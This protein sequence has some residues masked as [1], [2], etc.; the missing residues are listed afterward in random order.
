MQSSPS[1]VICHPLTTNE[2]HDLFADIVPRQQALW[3]AVAWDVVGH[4]AAAA[5]VQIVEAGGWRYALRHPWWR[6]RARLLRNPS[7]RIGRLVF[8]WSSDA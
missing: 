6:L 1:R 5:A 4:M 7:V 8:E 2:M 3:L